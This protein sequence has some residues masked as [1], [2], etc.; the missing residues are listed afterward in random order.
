M[1]RP[2]IP[3]RSCVVAFAAV[4][5][6]ASQ[7]LAQTATEPAAPPLALHLP[8]A[9]PDD[10]TCPIQ[11]Y[12]DRDAGPDVLDYACGGMTYDGHGG[13]DFRLPTR[14]VME[15]GVPVTA[16]AAGTVTG[17]RDGIAN[18]DGS[19]AAIAAAIAD[20][21]ECGNGV[22]IDHGGGWST[23][24]C[25]LSP[26]LAVK[27]GDRVAVGSTLGRV[28]ITGAAAFP[29]VHFTVRHDDEKLDPFRPDPEASCGVQATASLWAPD[30]AAALGYESP[31]LLNA[32]FA[33]GAVT[34]Q[35]IEDGTAVVSPAA[36]APALVFFTRTIGLKA[37]D[38]QT[39]RLTGPDGEV[40][41]AQTADPLDRDKA[42]WMLFTGRKRRGAAWPA[43]DYHG[44]LTVV[45]DGATVLDA[46]RTLTIAP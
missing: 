19:Q 29:H 24:Y 5:L 14:A 9:C 4:V 28:G 39:L 17:T 23:Q 41:S 20:E 3:G 13:T 32:G 1:N 2:S 10:I 8:L 26:G 16:A 30:V 21:K 37:G 35:A 42:Q 22:L 43:G 45:R 31:R 33:A 11:N 34:M 38:V 27:T 44:T 46:E 7:A 12:F 40:I 36:D 15:A 25:H 6:A 18:H